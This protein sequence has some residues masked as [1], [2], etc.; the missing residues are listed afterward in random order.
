LEVALSDLRLLVE[1]RTGPGTGVHGVSW[2]IK[3]HLGGNSHK[4]KEHSTLLE[5]TRTWFPNRDLSVNLV[6]N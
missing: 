3:G 1:S 6:F 5:Q 4:N 2:N